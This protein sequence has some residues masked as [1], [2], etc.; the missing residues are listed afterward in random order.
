MRSGNPSG[1]LTTLLQTSWSAGEGDILP[2]TLPS[3]RLLRL[4]LVASILTFLR[5]RPNEVPAWLR[6]YVSRV[7]LFRM[8][9]GLPVDTAVHRGGVLM[10]W[11]R[12][13]M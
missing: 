9:S 4:D 13:R 2:H 8:S 10:R 7:S 1:D 11:M 5:P 12:M 3:R 6:L